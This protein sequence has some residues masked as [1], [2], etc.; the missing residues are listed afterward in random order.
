M[1]VQTKNR[2]LTRP[3]KFN[4]LILPLV[5]LLGACTPV[6]DANTTS[7]AAP[8]ERG[9]LPPIKTFSNPNP[10]PP[11]RANS[12]IARDFLDLS[13][14]LE[15]GS[16][17]P[18][19]TRFE[20]PITV[21]I[22][23]V[24]PVTL[25]P[26]LDR[27]LRR[28]RSEAGINISRVSDGAANIT[29]EAVSRRDIH[30]FQPSAACFVVPNVS[31]LKEYSATWRGKSTSWG[32]MRQRTRLAIF[33]PNDVSPQET[34]DCLHEELAQA[35]GPLNDLYRLPDSIYNDDNMQTVLTGFDMLILRATYQPELYS[36]MTRQQVASRLPAILS[37]LNPPGDNLS[38]RLTKTTPRAWINAIETALGPSASQAKRMRAANR[39][40]DIA[41]SEG[42]FDHRLGF[43]HYTLGQLA[44]KSNPALSVQHFR[45]AMKAYQQTPGTAIQQANTAI[46][47][48][49]WSIIAG[50]PDVALKFI[51]PYVDTAKNHEDAALLANL[52]LLRAEA[53]EMMG[54]KDMAQA[55]RLD[56]LGWARYGFGTDWV[57]R[58]KLTKTPEITSLDTTN[59]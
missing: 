19:F 43:T 53:L 17:L 55:L 52:M 31:S 30:K 34:R 4:R 58:S 16:T 35:L 50:Q 8:P 49:A 25:L 28:L 32:D 15:S 41:T 23:G 20:S 47:L 11:A 56:S 21:R 9:T 44:K 54:D 18:V 51:L 26:D 27:L 42:W 39:A 24:P 6:P 36:G 33:I 2:F 7:R 14:Q 5:L 12:D 57:L 46:Q 29:I 48:A 37:R 40:L 13:F 1:H 45:A 22:T 3:V 59:G 10:Q 38:P